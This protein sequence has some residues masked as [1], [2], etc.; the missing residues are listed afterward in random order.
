MLPTFPYL[1]GI[2]CREEKKILNQ[3][4]EIDKRKQKPNYK[5]KNWFSLRCKAASTRVRRFC[6]RKCFYADTACV[7]TC[8]P[9]TL[10]VR[11]GSVSADFCVRSPE[12]KFLYTMCLRIRV[13]GALV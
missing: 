12:G 7:H 11:L 13:D 1:V 8:P 4:R 2:I 10:G 5:L 6:I 3:K 9:Y